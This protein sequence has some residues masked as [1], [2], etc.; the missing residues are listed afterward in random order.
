MPIVVQF[1][2]AKW[3]TVGYATTNV[4]KGHRMR[5]NI[6]M[7]ISLCL[8]VH[9]EESN[10]HIPLDSCYDWV[11]EIIIVDGNSTDRTVDNAQQYGN[12]IH[13]YREDNP[14]MFHINKQKAIEHATSDWIL[15]LD[16]DEA[17][18][19]EL[20]KE[21][22][23]IITQSTKE[24]TPPFAY[25][26]PRKNLF[27]DRFLMYGGVYPDYTIRLYRRGTV[28]FPC[29][30]VHENVAITKD[31]E[32]NNPHNIIGTLKEPLLHYADPSFSRYIHRWNRYTTIDAEDLIKQ[33]IQ[34]TYANVFCYF[35]WKPLTWFLST[36]IRHRG[37]KDR[38][39]GMVFHLFSAIRFWVIYIKAYNIDHNVNHKVR[40]DHGSPS[41]LTRK[42]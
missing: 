28:Y 11:D 1:A 29:R 17:V 19:P 33:G 16:A 7:T 25:R 20:R 35:V 37:Y 21:I 9:N 2:N 4:R 5:Y 30:S 3:R 42:G 14:P 10:I 39:A 18:S 40:K 27:L 23:T 6:V 38:F 15:Q 32:L 8:A 24:I 22:T 12:K 34:Y 26:I 13:I 31:Y 41:S 36:Y